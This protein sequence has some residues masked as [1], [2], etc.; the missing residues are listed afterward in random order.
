MRTI[1]VIPVTGPVVTISTTVID[2]GMTIMIIDKMVTMETVL[3]HVSSHT[4][5]HSGKTRFRLND[6]IRV[7]SRKMTIRDS[8]PPAPTEP[9]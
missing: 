8:Q 1:I 2:H 9:A 6:L 3:I 4:K 7:I 5:N